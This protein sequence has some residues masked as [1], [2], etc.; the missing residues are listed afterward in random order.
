MGDPVADW[1]ASRTEASYDSALLREKAVQPAYT[2][3]DSKT[4]RDQPVLVDG[5]KHPRVDGQFA[6]VKPPHARTPFAPPVVSGHG[7]QVQS[8]ENGR[9]VSAP[10]PTFYGPYGSM[11][12]QGVIDKLNGPRG[13][14]HGVL[15]GNIDGEVGAR[16]PRVF[17]FLGSSL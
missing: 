11:W 12:D 8:G 6:P 14:K 16:T 3:G 1:K 5:P 13:G 2:W 17:F 9:H 4:L 10:A 15:G 7:K